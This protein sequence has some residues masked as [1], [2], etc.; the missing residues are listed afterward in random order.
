MVHMTN[1]INTISVPKGAVKLF[2]STGFTKV[3]GYDNTQVYDEH[4]TGVIEESEVESEVEPGVDVEDEDAVFV[5]EIIEKPI[6]QW[7]SDEIKRFAKIKN[8]DL[9]SVRKI[10]EARK[11]VRSYLENM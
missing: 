10:S 5:A 4:I 9:D 7:S 3:D 1:G 2:E 6:S 11:I 8:I